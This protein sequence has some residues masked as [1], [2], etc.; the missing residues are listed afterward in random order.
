MT[1]TNKA[2]ILNILKTLGW[3]RNNSGYYINPETE[4]MLDDILC[5]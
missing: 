4:K 2:L 3:K 1:Y 5:N